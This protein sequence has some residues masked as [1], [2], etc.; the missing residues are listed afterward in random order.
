MDARHDHE[1]NSEQGRSTIDDVMLAQWR[2]AEG[3]SKRPIVYSVLLP[4]VT[5]LRL[6]REGPLS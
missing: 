2:L 1:R 5:V 6:A 4:G 3:S